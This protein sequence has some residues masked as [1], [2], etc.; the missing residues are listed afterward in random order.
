M[1]SQLPSLPEAK[2]QAKTHRREHADQGT[3]ISHSQSLEWVARQHGFRDWNAFH[4]AIGDRPPAAWTP[5]GRVTGTYLSQAFKATVVSSA[6][7]SPGWFRLTLDFDE[8]VDVVHFD[9]FSNFRKR[10]QCVVGPS[11]TT[12]EKTSDG[13]P[14]VVL[15]C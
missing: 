10:V 3:E 11:G 7:V 12:K 2:S 9:S 1:T 15:D 13:Q 8:P 14:H 6:P 4:A 5:D